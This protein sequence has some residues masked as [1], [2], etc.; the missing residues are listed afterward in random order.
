MPLDYDALLASTIEDE[1]FGYSEQDSM[2]Y[3]LGVGF[4]EDAADRN[5]LP[6]VYEGNGLQTVPTMASM[7]LPILPIASAGLDMSLLLHREERLDLYRPLP[8]TGRMLCNRHVAAVHDLGKGRGAR[9]VIQSEVRRAKDDTVLFTSGQTLIARG[10]G[11]FGG[12]RGT[13][14]ERHRLPSREPDL[15]CDVPTRSDQALLFR[16]CGD[17]NPLHA[18]PAYARESGFERPILHGR[19]TY[20]IA[21]RSILQTICDYD[22]TL[23]AGFDAR[24]TSPVYPGDVLTTEMWQDRNIVS[25]RCL[26]ASRGVVVID[27][28]KCTLAT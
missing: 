11:G 3:A 21:C 10:D 2:L 28:G 5:E 4:G 18:D 26:V 9:I 27:N 14:P 15:S 23:I 12:P 8:A 17:L 16:L 22:F 25:F 6:Y 24:F 7:L 1:P 13:G 19:C 20:G